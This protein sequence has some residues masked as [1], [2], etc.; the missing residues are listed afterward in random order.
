MSGQ[1]SI[2]AKIYLKFPTKFLCIVNHVCTSNSK[3]LL[4]RVNI[5]TVFI[6]R[7]PQEEARQFTQL[8]QSMFLG[9][10]LMD[11]VIIIA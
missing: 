3:V 11:Q 9:K 7:T 4:A 2:T 10:N 8:L 1:L 6:P 5:D